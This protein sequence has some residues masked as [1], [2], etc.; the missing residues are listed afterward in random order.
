MLD[1]TEIA[2]VGPQ[3]GALIDDYGRRLIEQQ[4]ALTDAAILDELLMG[5]V[6]AYVGAERQLRELNEVKDRFLGIAAHDLRNPLAALRGM[7][8]LLQMDLGEAQRREMLQVMHETADGMLQLVTDLLDV[9]VIESGKL[10]IRAKPANLAR[11]VRGRI[12]LL[13]VSAQAKQISIETRLDAVDDSMLDVDRFAQVV[14]NIIGNAVKFSPPGSTVHVTV[15]AA[16]D[17]QELSVRDQGPGLSDAD[18]ARLFGAFEK[19]SA[20]PTAG[21]KSTGLGLAIVKKIVDAHGG[22]IE[23]ASAPGSGAEFRISL[24][25]LPVPA[26]TA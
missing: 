13:A 20:R 21:E 15:R 11:L 14:D 17:R 12:R 6:M 23:V 26:P 4:A 24:P 19:L 7:C 18:R 25:A 22:T 9:A 2:K 10:D 5:L 3:V 1:V 8:E 16:G